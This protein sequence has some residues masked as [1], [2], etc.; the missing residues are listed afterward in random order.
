[1]ISSSDL[2]L[3]RAFGV[4]AKVG[5]WHQHARIGKKFS[6]KGVCRSV[7][8]F[9]ALSDLSVSRLPTQHIYDRCREN[10]GMAWMWR[11][12]EIAIDYDLR[13]LYPSCAGGFCVRLHHQVRERNAVVEARHATTGYNLRAGCQ[14]RSPA[15]TSDDTASGVN[16][17]YELGYTRIFSKQGRAPCTARNK[18]T[19]IVLSSGISYR[20]PDIQQ[21]RSRKV[22]VN[23]D[24]LLAR[25]HH[26]DLVA[27]FVERHLGKEVL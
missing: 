18:D 10:R 6:E 3:S 23:L 5:R 17:L 20:P 9:G 2:F 1:M 27:S 11:S 8:L 14:H 16:V 26:L 13:I 7:I 12:Y 25:G 21:A 15:D 22:A 4:T 19:N 24:R